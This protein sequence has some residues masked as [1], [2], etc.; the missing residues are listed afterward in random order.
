MGQ[1]IRHQPNNLPTITQKYA[2]FLVNYIKFKTI[3]SLLAFN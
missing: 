1:K 3:N 2:L